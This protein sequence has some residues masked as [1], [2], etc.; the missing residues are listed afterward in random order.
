MFV[1]LDRLDII[2]T[3][4]SIISVRLEIDNLKLLIS[5]NDIDKIK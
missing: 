5:L 2:V 4:L 1:S 3:N